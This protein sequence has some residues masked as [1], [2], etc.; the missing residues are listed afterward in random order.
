MHHLRRGDLLSGR[1]LVLHTEPRATRSRQFVPGKRAKSRIRPAPTEGDGMSERATTKRIF[2]YHFQRVMNINPITWNEPRDRGPLARIPGSRA[3]SDQFDL[4]AAYVAPVDDNGPLW[5]LR[6]VFRGQT[7]AP[8]APQ[9]SCAGG[10]YAEANAGFGVLGHRYSPVSRMWAHPTGAIW[11]RSSGATGLPARSRCLTASPG[12]R[13]S[14][15]SRLRRG[16]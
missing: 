5:P 2:L 14:S 13:C 16:G 3:T 8:G 7:C 9:R 6:F 10:S 15:K 11:A 4:D 12:A 1:A